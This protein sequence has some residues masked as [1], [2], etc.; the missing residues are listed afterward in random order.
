MYRDQIV[1]ED[2][3]LLIC[4]VMGSYWVYGNNKALWSESFL[5]YMTV[6]IALF[7]S[8]I[9]PPFML[10]LAHFHRKSLDLAKVYRWQGVV[11]FL[12]LDFHTHIVEDQSSD[13]FC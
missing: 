9:G 13:L 10:A 8:T 5:N 7:G 12:S 1:I 11:L 4:K 3:I 6:M 2:S